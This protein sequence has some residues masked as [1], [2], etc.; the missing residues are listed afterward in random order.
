MFVVSSV[1]LESSGKDRCPAVEG[2][3]GGVMDVL[4]HEHV[5]VG[6]WSDEGVVEV[7][8]PVV[9]VGGVVEVAVDAVQVVV[10][11][12]GTQV[13]VLQGQLSLQQGRVGVG[14][15]EVQVVHLLVVGAIVHVVVVDVELS[16]GQGGLVV[17]LLV[18]GGRGQ[19]AL[20]VAD[21]VGVVDV[22]TGHG[23]HVLHL[24]G[25]RDVVSLLGQS[26]HY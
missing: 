3:T 20:G 2:V 25:V 8:S 7:V 13:V 21:G 14:V 23:E 6:D 18:S 1:L 22:Q 15:V 9:V 4:G 11:V 16:L 24:G 12:D 26:A 10:V 5:G 17:T 19:D